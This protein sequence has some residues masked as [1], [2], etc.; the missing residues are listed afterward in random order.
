MEEFCRI[1]P[2]FE[3]RPKWQTPLLMALPASTVAVM[4]CACLC[5]AAAGG[6]GGSS[7]YVYARV[8]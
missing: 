5:G 2:T 4:D 1:L 6:G 3:N 8:G 7:G